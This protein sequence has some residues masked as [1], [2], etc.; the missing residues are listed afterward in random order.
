MP[1]SHTVFGRMF[2]HFKSLSDFPFVNKVFSFLSQSL[3]DVF[4]NSKRDG[5]SYRQ[6]TASTSRMVAF[7]AASRRRRLPTSNHQ[8]SIPLWSCCHRQ[9]SGGGS[10]SDEA[11]SL[12][13]CSVDWSVLT[14]SIIRLH[15][16]HE[17]S[18]TLR[19]TVGV[20]WIMQS[21]WA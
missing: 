21:A 8:R 2:P 15:G 13:V 10:S 11:V 4:I 18:Y 20:L 3:F 5:R 16:L 14:V 17:S 9:A 1:A 6:D 7:V 12:V 19:L